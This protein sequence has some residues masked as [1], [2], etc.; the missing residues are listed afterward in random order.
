MILSHGS[1]P[2][3]RADSRSW[4]P[5]ARGVLLVAAWLVLFVLFVRRVP[6]LLA[7]VADEGERR[8]LIQA[9]AGWA[10][11]A[12]PLLVAAAVN[13]RVALLARRSRRQGDLER[14]VTRSLIAIAA[15]P[16][17]A[18]LPGR[19]TSSR[20]RWEHTLASGGFYFD[21]AVRWTFFGEFA[22]LM[23]GALVVLLGPVAKRSRGI[24]MATAILLPPPL[25]MLG[26]VLVAGR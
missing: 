9:L 10:L 6:A 14:I 18:F 24:W 13:V 5:V 3:T 17:V 22:L 7:W 16:T 21:R 20:V 8:W 23:V 19:L 12:L 4:W 11:F 2:D 26:A 15:V 25:I 1:R